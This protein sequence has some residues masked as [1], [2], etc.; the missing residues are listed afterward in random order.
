MTKNLTLL[1]IAVAVL[2]GFAGGVCAQPMAYWVQRL[3]V[4]EAADQGHGSQVQIGGPDAGLTLWTT[5]INN[6]ESF[7]MMCNRLPDGRSPKV[8]SLSSRWVNMASW[9]GFAATRL[10][11]G[12]MENGVEAGRLTQV[13]W[14]NSAE[15]FGNQDTQPPP[16]RT[17]RING[18]LV[19]TGQIR[20]E[21]TW[22]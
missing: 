14:T 10:L 22:R 13:W 17:L 12:R 4:G 18:D 20:Q 19:V 3:V 2:S 7:L 6:R 11:V 5:D 8:M 9:D 21:A 1:L 15:F 16:D